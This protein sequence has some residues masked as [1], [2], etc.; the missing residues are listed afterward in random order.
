MRWRSQE[1]LS[2]S[3]QLQCETPWP[4]DTVCNNLLVISFPGILVLWF[5]STEA[6]IT[7][8]DSSVDSSGTLHRV[9]PYLPILPWNLTP[10]RRPPAR[11]DSNGA[12]PSSLKPDTAPRPRC[13][14]LTEPTLLFP[15]CGRHVGQFPVFLRKLDFAVAEARPPGEALFCKAA[16]GCKHRLSVHLKL[17]KLNEKDQSQQKSHSQPVTLFRF[18]K[19]SPSNLTQKIFYFCQR[20]CVVLLLCVVH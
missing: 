6:T 18:L 7:P 14:G 11:L 9:T 3:L 20:I 15:A 10:S 19:S 13:C 5:V 2:V 17:L 12:P 8:C 1:R 16:V 4:R